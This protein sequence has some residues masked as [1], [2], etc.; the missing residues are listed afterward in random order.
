MSVPSASAR[1]PDRPLFA[2]PTELG[3]T[4]SFILPFLLAALTTLGSLRADPADA[5]RTA[6]DLKPPVRLS[7]RLSQVRRFETIEFSVEPGRSYENPYDADQVAVDLVVSCP[8]GR[9]VRVPAFYAEPFEHRRI[10]DGRTRSDWL[11]PAGPGRWLARFA[12]TQVG[13]H[14][15]VVEVRD[16]LGTRRSNT[17]AFRCVPSQWHGFVRV[18]RSNPR[19]LQFTDGEPFFAVGQ[20]LAFLFGQQ[21]VRDTEK[22]EEVFRRLSQNGANFVRVWTGCGDWALC[23]EGRR[24]AWRRSWQ[25]SSPIVPA[26]SG[27]GQASPR[28]C[29]RLDSSS[30][31]TQ[32]L[33]PPRPV[34]LRPKTTYCLSGR[35]RSDGG[36]GLLVELNGRRYGPFAGG[37]RWKPF[38]CQFT[39]GADQ[40]WLRRGLFRLVGSGTV[41]LADVSLR[42]AAGG[43]ELLPEAK[44]EQPEWGRYNQRDAFL[45]DQVVELAERYGVY[46]QLCFLSGPLRNTYM[47]RLRQPG[48][49][50]YEDAVRHAR[51][52]FR[53]AVG[54]WGASR[55]VAVWEYFNE[56]DPRLPTDPFYSSLGHTLRQLDPYGRPRTTSSWHSNP[57]EW[58]HPELDVAN[59]HHYIR[60]TDKNNDWKDEVR[61]VLQRV[62]LLRRN[63]PKAKPALLAEF[64]LATP[65]WRESPDMRKDRSLSH[66]HNALWASS[67]SGLAGT[68]LFWWWER[69]DRMDAYRHY[70]PLAAFLHEVPFGDPALR[71]ASASASDERVTVV[72][73]ATGRQA[74]LWLFNTTAAW[75]RTVVEQR[76]REP[77]RG[78]RVQVAGLADGS[79]LVQWWDTWSG[80]R[81]AKRLSRCDGGTLS[82]SVPDFQRDVACHVVPASPEEAN[83]PKSGF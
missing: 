17:V 6:A 66:F 64:G 67:L 48:T 74:H 9:A 22:L 56:V 57:R 34:A 39:T 21:Y 31:S 15:A 73:L 62:E 32:T 80:R 69:L 45:L 78:C 50:E 83:G 4:A 7:S 47:R 68:A 43:P 13:P 29:V 14:T 10:P 12:P 27:D 40:W 46:L 36:A 81:L 60:P 53:Y 30:N 79:Y 33:S 49:P 52:L 54:R 41:W 2:R 16:E 24:S 37:S 63:L 77:I 82:V 35:F 26:P 38:R 61:V 5:V 3:R 25:R 42:E 59:E 70:K 28:L 58:R 1:L 76:S 72:G 19:F 44:L 75:Y 65:R 51:W 11:Y 71:R 20:N 23:I 55:A 8:D 18:G